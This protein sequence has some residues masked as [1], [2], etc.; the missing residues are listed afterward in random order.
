MNDTFFPTVDG[1]DPY[2]L[3]AEEQE[4]INELTEAFCN[5]PRLNRHVRF[6]YENGG[7][8]RKYNGNLLYHGCVPMNEDGSLR[9]VEL[10]GEKL[11]GKTYFDAAD[12]I[13]R[14]A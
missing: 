8:Y 14:H 11:S 6:L 2:A 13:A 10:F 9:T 5:S 1:N 3:T 7:M 4:V 12:E